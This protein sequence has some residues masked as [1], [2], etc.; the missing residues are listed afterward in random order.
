MSGNNLA[1]NYN[2]DDSATN[3]SNETFESPWLVD[4]PPANERVVVESVE[5]GRVNE[6]DFVSYYGAAKVKAD[7]ERAERRHR[8]RTE[9]L[10]GQYGDEVKEIMDADT[11]ITG[12][13]N[14]MINNKELISGRKI[15]SVIPSEYDK[16]VNNS[17]LIVAM[18]KKGG[19]A[20]Q[21]NLD[22]TSC[23]KV[24][25]IDGL[26][27]DTPG[28]CTDEIAYFE[29]GQTRTKLSNIPRYVVGISQEN[30]GAAVDKF[31]ISE[32]INPDQSI[33]T[34]I[35]HEQDEQTRFKILSEI[36]E[37]AKSR[38]DAAKNGS[39]PKNFQ[40]ISDKNAEVYSAVRS[41]LATMFG[42]DPIVRT[43]EELVQFEEKFN[44][45]YEEACNLTMELTHDKVYETIV[46]RSRNL[47]YG[48]TVAGV[49]AARDRVGTNRRHV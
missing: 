8:I 2:Y 16:E 18:E 25:N 14:Y 27:Q 30:A 10:R 5:K 7:K 19:G 35:S 3:N 15:A 29:Y 31:K 43:H 42:L 40:A 47:R 33:A 48:A 26:F 11:K 20:L 32:E 21:I 41:E 38:R 12:V 49:M 1:V 28:G 36:Y 46:K 23:D 22:I 4:F 37:Q 24:G 45:E 6:S 34:E 17:S 44:K 13:L 39:A 9:N